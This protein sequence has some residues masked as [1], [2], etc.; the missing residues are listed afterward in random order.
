MAI[1]LA[2]AAI[3]SR[4]RPRLTVE[5]FGFRCL[6]EGIDTTTA[7]GTP[8]FHVFA[9]PARFERV[10]DSERTMAGLAAARAR[11]RRGGSPSKFGPLADK[12]ADPRS[13][14]GLRHRLTFAIMLSRRPYMQLR[15]MQ[16]AW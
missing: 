1:D 10:L 11:P 15:S 16:A 9:P 7:G 4:K 14:K 13:A 3:D 12:D 6:T 2:I 5:A 8:V